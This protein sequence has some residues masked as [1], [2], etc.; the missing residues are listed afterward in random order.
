MR[1]LLVEDNEGLGDAVNRHLRN[2]GHSVEWVRSGED[3]L[4]AFA[5][6]PFDAVILDLSLPGRDGISVIAPS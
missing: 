5:L 2:A 3:A 4:E 6:E 1:M